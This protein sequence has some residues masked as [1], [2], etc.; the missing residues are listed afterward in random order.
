MPSFNDGGV[1]SGVPA[2]VTVGASTMIAENLNYNHDGSPTIIERRDGDGDPTGQVLIPGFGNGTATLQLASTA[3][4]PVTVGATIIWTRN[5]ATTV[6]G[7]ISEAG[8]A[9]TQLDARKQNVSFRRKY[10]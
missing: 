4:A 1:P 7:F 5:D 9:Y 8:E 3:T 6:G 2:V 10:N